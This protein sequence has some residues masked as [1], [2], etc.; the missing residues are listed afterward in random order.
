[1]CE[2]GVELLFFLSLLNTGKT[3]LYVYLKLSIMFKLGWFS[4]WPSFFF[5]SSSSTV[6]RIMWC[7]LVRYI[8]IYV[9]ELWNDFL[10]NVDETNINKS[11]YYEI[12]HISYSGNGYN[13]IMVTVI[14]RVALTIRRNLSRA[15]RKCC[16]T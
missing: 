10:L 3:S 7:M 13:N 9:F 16:V 11:F 4:R 2:I 8:L 5:F 6:E 14:S 1:M 15:K 12:G